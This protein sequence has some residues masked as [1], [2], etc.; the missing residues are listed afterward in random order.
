MCLIFVT[1]F[2]ISE[3]KQIISQTAGHRC[4]FGLGPVGP[5]RAL[6]IGLYRALYR[7]L[8]GLI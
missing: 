4:E 7:A 1:N 5:N 8:Q 3:N 2:Q 6:P